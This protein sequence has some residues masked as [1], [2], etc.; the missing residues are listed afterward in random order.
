MKKVKFTCDWCDDISL[1]T[2]FVKCYQS[3]LFEINFSIT[4]DDDYDVLVTVNK[5]APTL[6]KQDKKYIGVFMEP[7]W[8]LGENKKKSIYASCDYVLTY[9]KN[10]QFKN[11]IYYPGL[12]PFHLTYDEGPNLDYYLTLQNNK[13]N[14]CSIIV[15]RDKISYNADILYKQRV[16][17]A[18]KIIETD[19][20]IDIYGKG[21]DE[22][23]GIDTR[24]KGSLN[25]E[26]KY[27]GLQDYKFSICIENCSEESYFTEKITD[28]ILV[29]TIPIYYGCDHIQK[30]FKTPIMLSTLNSSECIKEIGSILKNSENKKFNIEDKPLLAN[31]FNLFAAL[32]KLITQL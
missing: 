17:L 2:R 32:T 6:K 12:L 15:S 22:L 3:T 28:S 25:L 26:E 1:M 4:A 21:W 11:N 20:P 13:P 5:P 14:L 27:K 29:N 23:V 19:L 18:E 24:I 8:F 10:S 16:E 30:F 31:K 9:I 7:S